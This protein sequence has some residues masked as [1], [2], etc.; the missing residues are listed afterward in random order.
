MANEKINMSEFVREIR[1]KQGLDREP[2][3]IDTIATTITN[4]TSPAT[5]KTGRPKKARKIEGGS[6]VTVFFDQDT[7]SKLVLTKVSHRI[8]MKDLIFGATL[9]FLDKYYDNGEL[10][11]AGLRELEKTLKN[12]YG[13]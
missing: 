9:M 12:F 8:E 5:T 6:P 10:S 11:A 7:K 13:E 2:Q 1:D 4:T 3:G